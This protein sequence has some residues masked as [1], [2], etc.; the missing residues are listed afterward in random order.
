MDFVKKEG[1]KL[2]PNKSTVDRISSLIAKNEGRCICHNESI[3]PHC[4]CTD[5]LEKGICHC[6]L[7]IKE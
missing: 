3:D 7:Y 1:F 5:F 4:A 6:G 2:N